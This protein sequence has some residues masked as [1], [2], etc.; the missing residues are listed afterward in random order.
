MKVVFEFDGVNDAQVKAVNFQWKLAV[1]RRKYSVR[2]EYLLKFLN[3][4]SLNKGI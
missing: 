1:F 4:F 3:T 2:M